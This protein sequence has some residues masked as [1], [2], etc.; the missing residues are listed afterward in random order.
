M[1]RRSRGLMLVLMASALLTITSCG[2][3]GPLM[4]PTEV[5]ADEDDQ[6]EDEDER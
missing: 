5:P 4:L 2:Q 1:N 3:M 6:G